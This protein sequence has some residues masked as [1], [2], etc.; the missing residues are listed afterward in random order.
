MSDPAPS[1]RSGGRKGQRPTRVA[2]SRAAALPAEERRSAIIAAT[3]PLLL[4]HGGA[5]RTRQIAE[6]AGIAEGTIFRVFP[7]KETLIE[8]AVEA[9]FDPEPVEAALL[10]IDPALPLEERLVEA[11]DILQRRVVDIWNL[12]SAVGVTKI[13]ANRRRPPPLAGLAAVFE[14]DRA[15]LRRDPVA[16]AQL[17]R[18]LTIGSSHP[19]LIVDE[20]LKPAEIVSILL[21]GVRIPPQGGTP[22]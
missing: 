11:V 15:Q 17:L 1:A 10:A 7:D 18:G 14:P 19:G 12:M 22:P 21:D 20:P 3:V 2:R 16:A 13:A 9:A 5:V 8:A 6:A 4:A